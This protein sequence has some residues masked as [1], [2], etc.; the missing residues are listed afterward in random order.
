MKQAGS[1]SLP[2]KH[3]GVSFTIATSKMELFV[4]SIFH[5]IINF[6]QDSIKGVAEVLGP[7]LE[8]YNVL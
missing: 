5:P 1:I 4:T 6:N 3:R 7:S 8:Q 2:N